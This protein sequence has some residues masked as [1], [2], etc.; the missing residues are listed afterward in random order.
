[1]VD[2]P[3][4]FS[5]WTPYCFV[6]VFR[7]VSGFPF[8]ILLPS[9]HDSASHPCM[10]SHVCTIPIVAWKDPQNLSTKDVVILHRTN[11]F[12]WLPASSFVQFSSESVTTEEQFSSRQQ[13]CCKLSNGYIRLN[14]RDLSSYNLPAR[15]GYANSIYVH[16]LNLYNNFVLF[17]GRVWV[18]YCYNK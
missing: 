8:C 7:A 17:Q 18:R 9:T 10:R 12:H 15:F 5:F 4:F 14:N 16:F 6:S 2:Q 11:C 1:M 13:V 3:D